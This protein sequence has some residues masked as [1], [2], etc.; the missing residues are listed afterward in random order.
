MVK[1]SDKRAFAMI[2]VG[3]VGLA[4]L[5]AVFGMDALLK[6]LGDLSIPQYSLSTSLCLAM[7]S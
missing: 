1:T 5:G 4:H 7:N 3:L 2:S 6:I